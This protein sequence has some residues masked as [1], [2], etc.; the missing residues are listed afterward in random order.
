MLEN[1]YYIRWRVIQSFVCIQ[2][3]F[4]KSSRVIARYIRANPIAGST[5]EFSSSELNSSAL[6]GFSAAKWCKGRFFGS[7]SKV[8]AFNL[9]QH[10]YV[11]LTQ[12]S[13]HFLC[14]YWHSTF[15]G[16]GLSHLFQWKKKILEKIKMCKEK[17]YKL[18]ILCQ[19]GYINRTW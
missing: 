11:F 8:F 1:D 18:S 5:T 7:L 14:M 4:C 10:L 16:F 12:F 2:E 6:T 19:Q 13:A 17:K 9:L 15:H 3:L